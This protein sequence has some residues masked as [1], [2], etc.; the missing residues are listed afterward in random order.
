LRGLHV[1]TQIPKIIGAANAFETTGDERGRR[2]AEYFW[3]QVAEHRS[4]CTGGASNFEHF[5][6]GPD[7]LAGELSSQTHESCCTYNML[8]LT[9]R[10]FSW[11]ADPRYAEYYER[12]LFNGILGTITPDEGTTMYFVPMA[13][14]YW[15]IFARPYDSFW[16]CTGSGVESFS[17]LADSIY[18]HDNGGLWVNL[19]VPSELNWPEQKIRIRQETRFPDEGSSTITVTEGKAS[20]LELRLRVPQWAGQGYKVRVNGKPVEGAMRAGSY[21]PI[22]RNWQ[23]GDK[24]EI[25]FPMQLR[26]EALR[27]DPSQQALM[28][29][30][31]VL[32]GDLGSEGLTLESHRGTPDEKVKNHYLRGE[33]V[34]VPRLGTGD[35][36]KWVRR[37][38]G[39]QL[40][41]VATSPQRTPF[42]PLS[43]ISDQ[44][45]VVY[46]PVN[47]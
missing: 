33:P 25:E 28:Y 3:Q 4:Y 38:D 1:N 41:F 8:K 29:G 22:R 35:P 23:A 6:K 26:A 30:P 14:G 39:Q 34:A 31:I 45:Y 27:G 43:R 21:V 18:F 17:K 13:G 46:W 19:F 24:V 11:T 7:D 44:R 37:E 12:A 10:L 9:R 40:R 42:I 2:I 36:A 32:A 16:C 5:R 15:K 47:G 20:G